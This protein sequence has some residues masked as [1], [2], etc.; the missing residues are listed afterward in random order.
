MDARRERGRNSCERP[1]GAGRTRRLGGGSCMMSSRVQM[2]VG[3]RAASAGVTGAGYAVI[4]ATFRTICWSGSA[5]AGYHPGPGAM[6]GH[7]I[8][9]CA[10]DCRAYVAACRGRCGCVQGSGSRA[11]EGDIPC[12]G[13][14]KCGSARCTARFLGDVEVGESSDVRGARKGEVIVQAVGGDGWTDK[15][16]VTRGTAGFG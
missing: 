10:A 4:G 2:P 15:A 6:K 7:T 8:K 11:K 5:F 12:E 14:E 16:L 9:T 3:G 13:W 1:S